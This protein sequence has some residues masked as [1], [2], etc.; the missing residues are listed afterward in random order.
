[1]PIGRVI[2][3][4]LMFVRSAA[5]RAFGR[6]G[7]ARLRQAIVPVVD[8]GGAI[9]LAVDDIADL[10]VRRFGGADLI[11]GC[12]RPARGFD[13]RDPFPRVIRSDEHTSELQSLM[14]TLTAVLCLQIKKFLLLLLLCPL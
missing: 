14:R 9:A 11:R 2:A 7:I 10:A 12:T 8:I 4:L 13:L 6:R 3:E 5:V 1:M